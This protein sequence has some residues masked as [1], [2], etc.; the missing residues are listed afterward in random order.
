MKNRIKRRLQLGLGLS[1]LILVTVSTVSYINI[2]NLITSAKLVDHS[3]KVAMKLEHIISISKDA[4]TGQHG[5]LLTN[6]EEFLEPYNGAYQ[7][8]LKLVFQ[9]KKLTSDNPVQQ[10]NA[11]DLNKILTERL[12][13]IQQLLEKRRDGK[14]VTVDDLRIGKRAMDA[15]KII[16]EKAKSDEKRLLDQ[17]INELNIYNSVTPTLVVISILLAILISVFSYIKIIRDVVQR[18]KLQQV[19]YKQEQ[20]TATINEELSAANEEL[21]SLNEEYMA[22]NEE[23]TDSRYRLELLNNELEQRVNMRTKAL[24]QSQNKL[25]QM[26]ESLPQ[27]AWT[28][29]ADGEV[30]FYNKRWFEYTGLDFEQTKAWG[31]KEVI[32]P[33]DLQHNLN[34]YQSILSGSV[35]GEFEI[36]ERRKDGVYRWHLIRM[37]PVHGEEGV[38]HWVG[39]ATDIE[40]IKQLQQQKDD[41]ISIASHELKTPITVLRASLQMLVRIKDVPAH[42]KMPEMIGRADA[43]V[44]KLVNLIEDLLNVSKMN[45]DQLHLNKTL[46]TIADIIDECCNHVRIEGKYSIVTSGDLKLKA[47]GDPERIVQVVV[48]FLNNAIKY[49]PDS[50]EIKVLI[51][52]VN[53][54]VRVSV[55]DSGF[56]IAPEKIPYLFDRYYRVDSRGTQ[57]SGLGL[58]LYI[59]AEIIRKHNGEIG[60]NSEVGKGSTFWFSIPQGQYLDS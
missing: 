51:E 36:R 26:M 40:D 30:D 59:C 21:G 29:K 23:L 55:T 22:T 41:F 1:L 58:G 20:E 9:F 11:E 25:R 8:S 16:L 53:E 35:G 50:K 24:L 38:T 18:E 54:C 48:N 27:I 56:G 52:K 17:R 6:E 60:V 5:F 33:D 46:F 3:N 19:L 31:W 12:N 47:Y 37:M 28:N 43:S 57:Y 15:L 7:K 32:H 39:T 13:I 14:V 4:E 49:A 34:S 10:L 45:Y 42:P 2:L 44:K